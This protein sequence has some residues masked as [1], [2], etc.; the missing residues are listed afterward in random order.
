MFGQTIERPPLPGQQFIYSNFN[1]VE[2]R[3][4]GVSIYYARDIARVKYILDLTYSIVQ[5]RALAGP[6]MDVRSS[7]ASGKPVSVRPPCGRSRTA[8]GLVNREGKKHAS[9]RGRRP[10]PQI[11]AGKGWESWGGARRPSTPGILFHTFGA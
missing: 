2:C 4:A 9:A 7:G 3:S 10:P 11:G 6:R 1:H 8:N 5:R